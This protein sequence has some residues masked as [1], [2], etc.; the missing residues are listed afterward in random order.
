LNELRAGDTI[1]FTNSV[2]RSIYVV[3][4]SA[5]ISPD[6]RSVLQP[7]NADVLTLLTCTPPHFATHRLEV[8]ALLHLTTKAGPT[9]PL[10]PEGVA[11][12]VAATNGSWTLFWLV[13]FASLALALLVVGRSTKS[14]WPKIG[15]VIALILAATTAN[16]LLVEHLPAGF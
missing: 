4:A 13:A 16:L 8:R 3:T 12:P 10:P 9:A 2:G 14:R 1:M 11:K 6:D 7:T 5:V 15:G